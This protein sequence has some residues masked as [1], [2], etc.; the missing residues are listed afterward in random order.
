MILIRSD[1]IEKL[2]A[3]TVLSAKMVFNRHGAVVF[4]AQFE[5][6]T[7]KTG[8]LSYEDDYKGNALAAIL[9]RET[10]EIRYHEAFINSEVASIARNLLECPE[11]TW[12]SQSRITYQGRALQL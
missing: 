9:T 2:R 6:R 5:H 8:D 1:I 11:M 4:P 12:L 3:G 7:V 10:I